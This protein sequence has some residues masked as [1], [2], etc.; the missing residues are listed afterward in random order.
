MY[1]IQEA[2]PPQRDRATRYVGECVL[3]HVS[4]GV[5]VRNV[6]NGKCD[7]QGHSR[8]L[9][10]VLFDRPHTISCQRSI[11]LPLK[12]IGNRVIRYSASEFL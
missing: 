11:A 10:M 4:R 5:R 9:A 8:A 1:N 12:V 6:S 7:L 3:C 2:Q